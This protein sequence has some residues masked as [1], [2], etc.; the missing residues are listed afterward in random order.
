MKAIKDSLKTA[1]TTTTNPWAPCEAQFKAHV[2][3][4]TYWEG[5]PIAFI[6]Y[7]PSGQAPQVCTYPRVNPIEHIDVKKTPRVPLGWD[8]SFSLSAFE[9]MGAVQH[10]S[11]SWLSGHFTECNKAKGALQ[12]HPELNANTINSPIW[13]LVTWKSHCF[14]SL[15]LLPK[16]TTATP[17][18]ILKKNHFIAITEEIENGNYGL[19]FK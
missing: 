16:A 12:V 8:I 4:H 5:S 6:G 1:I 17:Y 7:I 14:Q 19:Q 3:G 18:S 11:A 9:N 13:I 2:N 10:P 15:G